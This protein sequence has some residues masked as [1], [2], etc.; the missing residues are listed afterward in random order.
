MGRHTGPV[1]CTLPVS[2]SPS[3]FLWLG[4]GRDI[5]SYPFPLTLRCVCKTTL[6]E[7]KCGGVQRDD[8]SVISG[9][10]I[11]AIL[12]DCRVGCEPSLGPVVG[13]GIFSE[14]ME[15]INV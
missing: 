11:P 7:L 13:G 10:A 2:G 6:G 15:V 5:F 12:A 8:D 4:S 1:G 9:S 14:R 3:C